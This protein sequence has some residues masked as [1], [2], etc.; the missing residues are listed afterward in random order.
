MLV[1]PLFQMSSSPLILYIIEGI[2]G[3][4]ISGI[5]TG[6]RKVLSSTGKGDLNC[7]KVLIV[8]WC[9]LPYVNIYNQVAYKPGRRNW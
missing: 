4:K 9:P 7:L 6:V 8:K 3:G 2:I 1:L 5:A